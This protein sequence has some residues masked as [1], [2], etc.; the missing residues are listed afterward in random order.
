MKGYSK[1]IFDVMVVLVTLPLTLPLMGLV[2]LWIMLDGAGPIVHRQL[3]VGR[4]G[5]EFL[6]RK[7]RTLYADAEV[8][9]TVAPGGD[10]RITRPGRFLRKWRLDEL[11]QVLNVLRGEMSLVGPRPEMAEHLQAIP[12]SVRKK[13]YSVRPGITGPAAVAFLAEDEYLATVPNPV[14]V[15][16]EILLPEKLR[17]EFGYVEHWKFS[18]DLILIGQTALRLFSSEARR[19]SRH[20]IEQIASVATNSPSRRPSAGIH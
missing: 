11:P 14:K 16:R 2:A 18:T 7:F 12:A 9:P 10:P 6:I 19:R 5:E 8:K 4:G 3:R 20:M 1:R 17:L 13:V 15:Y